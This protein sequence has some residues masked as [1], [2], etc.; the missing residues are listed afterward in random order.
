ML[1]IGLWGAASEDV[2]TFIHQN[3][4]LES[5]LTEL[6]GRKVLYSHTYYSEEEFWGL[7]DR[8]WYHRL[9]RK[10]GATSLPNLYDK[11]H[12][13]VGKVMGEHGK[14]K[15]ARALAGFWSIA[16]FMGIRAAIRSKD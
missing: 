13:D 14:K 15:R 6:G 16:G 10:Y 8:P 4:E 12:V 1:N 11:V 5:V 7:Y 2:G 3:R 9:R